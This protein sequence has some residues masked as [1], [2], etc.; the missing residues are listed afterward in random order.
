M[1]LPPGPPGAGPGAGAP[2]APPAGGGGAPAKKETPEWK[3]K[4]LTGALAVWGA[5]EIGWNIIDGA[6]IDRISQ[7]ALR[8]INLAGVVQIGGLCKDFYYDTYP[9]IRPSI[10]WLKSAI[11]DSTKNLFGRGSTTE[12]RVN[13]LVWG[14]APL[15][16]IT[17][18]GGVLEWKTGFFSNACDLLGLGFGA[19]WSYSDYVLPVVGLY[20]LAK[21]ETVS[22]LAWKAGSWVVDFGANRVGDVF[23]P[24]WAWVKLAAGGIAI[25][26]AAELTAQRLGRGSPT[27]WTVDKGSKLWDYAKSKFFDTTPPSGTGSL[28]GQNELI[29][30]GNVSGNTTNSSNLY[31]NTSQVSLNLTQEQVIES[32][33]NKT[34]DFINDFVPIAWNN[35]KAAASFGAFTTWSITKSLSWHF[36]DKT[37]WITKAYVAYFGITILGGYIATKVTQKFGKVIV[38]R[39]IDIVTTYI[40]N[41]IGKPI[42]NIRQRYKIPIVTDLIT[43]IHKQW[44][45]VFPLDPFWA[46]VEPVYNKESVDAIDNVLKSTMQIMDNPLGELQNVLLFG[47]PGTGKTELANKIMRDADFE[48]VSW[49]GPQL[50]QLIKRGE[51]VSKLNEIMQRAHDGSKPTLFFIDEVETFARRREDLDQH[52]QEL[53]TALLDWTSVGNKK[54]MIIAA[55]NRPKELDSAFLSRMFHQ[56]EIAVPNFDSRKELF[57]RYIRKYFHNMPEL[58]D[59]FSESRLVELALKTQGLTGRSIRQ[60]VTI[61]RSRLIMSKAQRLTDAEIHDATWRMV[62]KEREINKAVGRGWYERKVASL[63]DYW[64]FEIPAQRQAIM[65]VFAALKS[66]GRFDTYVQ[67]YA[68]AQRRWTTFFNPVGTKPDTTKVATLAKGVKVL[69]APPIGVEV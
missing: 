27:E 61:L 32:V 3:R 10:M 23:N 58:N 15:G 60:L 17:G 64:Y 54:V 40:R 33:S 29:N 7:A 35:T 16:V 45:R 34:T 31:H 9:E 4:A 63:K 51:A 52:R 37:N 49:S 25:T 66:L 59:T 68:V 36:W 55:T 53:L 20:G 28:D 62:K 44:L 8:C 11:W 21:V 65:R 41:S 22:N 24:G 13:A 26:S 47:Y 50:A 1:I 30:L 38:D 57:A 69:A 19:A 6:G 56:I 14:L 2:A 39:V 67:F 48:W 12:E 18:L 43:T 46:P 42:L 5:C